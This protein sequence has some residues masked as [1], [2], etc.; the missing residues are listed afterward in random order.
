[1]FFKRFF[2]RHLLFGNVTP[3]DQKRTMEEVQRRKKCANMPECQWG[4]WLFSITL[5][6]DMGKTEVRRLELC[7]SAAT[8]FSLKPP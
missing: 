1:M 7:G 8:V 4:I 2:P 5:K 6:S 3:N